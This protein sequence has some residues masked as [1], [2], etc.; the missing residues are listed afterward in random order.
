MFFDDMLPLTLLIR[1]LFSPDF[2]DA[3]TPGHPYFALRPGRQVLHK[4]LQRHEPASFTDDATMQT[5]RHHLWSSCIS[6]GKQDV[7]SR[8]QILEE[9]LWREG[10]CGAME[11]QVVVVIAE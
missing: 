4:S 11:L 2:G 6:F 10:S 3:I 5:Y 9:R 8:L 7:E 1:V